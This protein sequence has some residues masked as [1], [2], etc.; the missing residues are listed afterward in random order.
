MKLNA[1]EM[2]YV[3][4]HH[5]CD[6][7][8]SARLLQ[9]VAGATPI[10]QTWQ[11][12]G[13]GPNDETIVPL[14][15]QKGNTIYITDLGCS[16][17][18]LE[19]CQR[20]SE[21]NK[22]VLIDHHPP[23]EGVRPFDYSS[24]NFSVI[25]SIDNCASGLIREYVQALDKEVDEWTNFWAT[26]GITADVAEETAG[27]KVILDD[28]RSIFPYLFWKRTYWTG[29]SEFSLS[30]ASSLG[31]IIN[32]ARRLTYHYGA[33]IAL[34]AM[35]EMEQGGLSVAIRLIPQ[36]ADLTEEAKYPHLALLRRWYN[37]WLERREEVFK[38]DR[39]VNMDFDKFGLSIINHPWDI[40][41]YVANVKSGSKPWIAINY[42][43]PGSY[44]NLAARV[45]E[46]DIDFNKIMKRL[47]AVTEGKISGG[48]HPMAAGG[49][50]DKG[51]PIEDVIK[52]MEVVLCG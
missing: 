34:E 17:E 5:D 42:G 43:V 29:R 49:M 28:V 31:A 8:V 26:V 19:T 11:K 14:L 10:F 4:S 45:R 30:I 2:V 23:E 50:V 32:T 39:I 22:V 48:G 12:F 41:G 27:G 13:I 51:Y 6:G 1:K 37:L 21:N 7:I 16:K 47:E 44:A 33:P 24:P 46:G 40:A 52:N 15:K 3:I 38:S 25:H 18:T 35:K 20:L 9:K 36:E